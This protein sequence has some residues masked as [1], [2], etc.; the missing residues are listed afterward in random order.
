MNGQ[1]HPLQGCRIRHKR[2]I[3]HF[4]VIEAE[5]AV[6]PVDEKAVTFRSDFHADRNEIV[7]SLATVPNFPASW[8]VL[9]S[10]AFFNLRAVLDYLAWQLACWN[11]QQQG[12]ARDPHGGTQFP[13]ATRPELFQQEQVRDLHP[14]HRAEIERLQPY[15]CDQLSRFMPGQ[16]RPDNWHR[17]TEQTPLARLKRINDHDK[18]RLLRPIG[19]S[20][21][22]V[23]QGEVVP[24]NCEIIRAGHPRHDIRVGAEWSVYTVRPTGPHPEMVVGDWVVPGVAFGDFDFTNGFRGVFKAVGAVIERFADVFPPEP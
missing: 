1:G 18:H 2:A 4:H 15:S 10:E 3:D 22:A 6:L 11:L 24:F 7:V 9:A 17:L 19:A 13:I 12:K 20:V 8:G 23:M 5:L 16:V 14:D 21:T